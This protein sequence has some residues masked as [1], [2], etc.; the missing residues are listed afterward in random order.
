VAEEEIRRQVRSLRDHLPDLRRRRGVEVRVLEG[1]AVDRLCVRR[2][3]LPCDRRELGGPFDVIG[4]VHGCADELDELL[5]RLGYGP[6]GPEGGRSHSAGRRAVFLGDLLDRGPRCLDTLTRVT[7][8]VEAGQAL[9][10]LGNHDSKLLRWLEGRNVQVSDGLQRTLDELERLDRAVRQRVSDRAREFFAGLPNHL[11]LDGGRLVVAH[12]GI[13]EEMI[14]RAGAAVDAFTRYGD[15]TGEVDDAGLPVRRDW[16][17]DYR[18]SARVVYGHTP[19]GVPSWV[20]RT[21]NIDQGC[22]FGGFLTAVRYPELIFVQVPAR[23]VYSP[24]QGAFR[25]RP[26]LTG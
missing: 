1:G 7:G 11:V 18:G 13:R 23:R 3:R 16:A 17:A 12:G 25:P 4:D 20:N 8:M 9:C 21:A 24:P 14:G 6:S 26:G 19:T 10:V 22:C 2:R 5:G 15:T